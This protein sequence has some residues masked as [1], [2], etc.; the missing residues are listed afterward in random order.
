LYKLIQ[1]GFIKEKSERKAVKYAGA[2]DKKQENCII[3]QI[4]PAKSDA[5]IHLIM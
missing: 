3:I 2:G 5:R 1:C 4:V